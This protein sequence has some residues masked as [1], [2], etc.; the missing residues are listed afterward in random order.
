MQESARPVAGQGTL[1]G[2]RLYVFVGPPGGGPG[3]VQ[4]RVSTLYA[5][6]FVTI[7]PHLPRG[8]YPDALFVLDKRHLWFTIY[9][10][11]GGRERL[12]RTSDAGTTWHWTPIVS[13]SMA[14]GSTDALWFTDADHGWLTDIQ[15]TGPDAA[16]YAT[17]DGGR[18]WQIVAD[19][20]RRGMT[21]SL[22]TL[23]RVAYQPDNTTAWD[24]APAYYFITAL[25]VTR[26]G[27]VNWQA[28]LSGRHRTF[29]APSVFGTTVLEPVSW[30]ARHASRVRLFVSTDDGVRWTRTPAVGM[31]GALSGSDGG[32][33]CQPI[34]A[35][36]PS[37]DVAWVA[38]AAHGKRLVVKHT[39]DQGQHWHSAQPP[40]LRVEDIREISATD[41][42]RALLNVR[43]LRGMERLYL[44]ND[45]GITWQSIN[46]RATS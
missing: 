27:G 20:D 29:T 2:R 44:T 16:L 7:G 24:A 46:R 5:K 1:S 31:G 39:C 12:Y 35:A 28:A 25:Y 26:N 6:R 30:C 37:A 43:D 3:S 10:D 32:S 18:H 19:T 9:W 13:H 40:P 23:G 41:C 22:P 34:A 42:R 17:A 33:D 38:A 36:E 45:G 21:R 11:G 8:F 15:P 14:G 4:L